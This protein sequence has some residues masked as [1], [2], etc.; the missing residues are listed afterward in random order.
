MTGA[1]PLQYPSGKG[2]VIDKADLEYVRELL[3]ST[4]VLCRDAAAARSGPPRSSAEGRRMNKVRLALAGALVLGLTLGARAGEGKGGK[5]DVQQKLVGTWEVVKFKGKDPKDKGPPPGM[6]MAF[7]KDGKVTLAAEVEGKKRSF[8][9]T[10][11]VEGTSFQMTRK[12]GDTEHTETM[13]VL[14]VD[15]KELVLRGGRD[16][17]EWTLKRKGAKPKD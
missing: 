6:T 1:R 9:G 12:V 4:E 8:E 15:D 17:N 10:Y 3:A 14:R 11:K 7:T 13:K 5:D 16:G 2:G